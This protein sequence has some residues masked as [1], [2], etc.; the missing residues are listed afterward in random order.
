MEIKNLKLETKKK[1]KRRRNCHAWTRICTWANFLYPW[2]IP[3]VP[4]CF[5]LSGG[6]NG[7]LA[8]LHVRPSGSSHAF[9]VWNDMWATVV[10]HIVSTG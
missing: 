10:S 4:L 3:S 8:Q 9:I 2:G 7:R 1:N 5:L 6:P